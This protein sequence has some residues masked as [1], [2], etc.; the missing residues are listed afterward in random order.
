MKNCSMIVYKMIAYKLMRKKSNW[1]RTSKT[2]VGG[3][4]Q[5]LSGNYNVKASDFH[6]VISEVLFW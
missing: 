5:G 6:Q 1:E 2:N 4:L 3:M